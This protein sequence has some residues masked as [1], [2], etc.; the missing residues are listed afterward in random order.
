MAEITGEGIPAPAENIVPPPFTNTQA[1][2]EIPVESIAQDFGFLHDI[3]VTV[4]VE[5]GRANL[6]LRDVLKLQRGSL[7]EL[8]RLV[9]Q[10]AELSIN[11][12]PMAKGDVIV[13]NNRFGFRISKLVSPQGKK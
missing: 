8:D 11:N 3:G 4:T 5:L 9:G 6:P 2:A 12:V 10:P 1:T 13:L 7:V